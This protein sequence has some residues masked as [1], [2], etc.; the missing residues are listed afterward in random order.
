MKRFLTIFILIS[1]ISPLVIPCCYV[2]A[3]EE[4]IYADIKDKEVLNIKATKTKYLDEKNYK[5]D[6][7][8]AKLVLKLQKE[9]DVEDLESLWKATVDRNSAIRFALEKLATP[10]QER[11]IHSSAMA[12]TVSTLINGASLVPFMAGANY[13]LQTA[14]VA[15]G[16]IANRLITNR[17]LPKTSP[18]TDTEL[19]QLSELVEDL[20]NELVRSYYDYKSSISA[21]KTCREKLELEQKNYKLAL[22][23]DNK[24]SMIVAGAIYDDQLLE[25]IQLKEQIKLN[26]LKLE[27]LA[28]H[29]A[30]EALN[31]S[32]ISFNKTDIINET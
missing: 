10:G 22:K 26:R 7:E 21:L 27:R 32:R 18:L 16:Q 8:R 31:L 9:K 1:F 20:Q 3:Q 17:K 6:P 5:N 24:F 25:E 13:S 11:H 12:K 30:V 19:I 2:Q 28:G 4:V 15:T 23:D 14:S 29:D